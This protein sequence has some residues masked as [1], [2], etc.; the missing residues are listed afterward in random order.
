MYWD[1]K[2]NIL[3]NFFFLSN[4]WLFLLLIFSVTCSKMRYTRN[5]SGRIYPSL[6]PWLSTLLKW[7]GERRNPRLPKYS[8]NRGYFD[9]MAAV[10][11]SWQSE[12][13][14]QTKQR[15]H[16]LQMTPAFL[17]KFWQ[18]SPPAFLKKVLG[19]IPEAHLSPSPL[20]NSFFYGSHVDGQ[21]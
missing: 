10:F 4:C 14:V 20:S 16:V 3:G 1:T 19:T 13:V 17:G 5:S 11:V 18:P 2:H 7:R 6:Y 8:K 21:K 12:S 9:R 15:H